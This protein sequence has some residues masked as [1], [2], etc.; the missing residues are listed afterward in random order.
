[1]TVATT[2]PPLEQVLPD[3]RRLLESSNEIGCLAHKD[4]ARLMKVKVSVIPDFL[5]SVKSKYLATH[6]DADE[7]ISPGTAALLWARE[8]G[9]C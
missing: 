1:M 8:L 7:S 6:P 4:A 2:F 3:I 9:M 5:K